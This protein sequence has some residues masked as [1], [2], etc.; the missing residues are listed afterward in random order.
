MKIR[1]SAEDYLESVLMLSETQEFV[2]AA[3]LCRRLGFSRPTVSQAVHELEAD[4]YLT[5]DGANHIT[6]TEKGHAIAARTLERHR[7]ISNIFL[8]LGVSEEVAREDACR[9][10]HYISP[11]TFRCMKEYYET[12]I[13]KSPDQP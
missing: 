1:E 12:K 4:G 10:E 2:R 6:L 5:L 8:S 13:Q 3:D 9:V 7:V 11:E